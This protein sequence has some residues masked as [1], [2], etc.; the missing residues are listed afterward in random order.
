MQPEIHVRLTFSGCV[1][2]RTSAAAR[3]ATG[4]EVLQKP[5]GARASCAGVAQPWPKGK[6]MHASVS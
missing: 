2:A 6:T 5:A 1:M 3:A 4:S